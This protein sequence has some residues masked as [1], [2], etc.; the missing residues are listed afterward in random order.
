MNLIHYSDRRSMMNSIE[1]RMPF[2]DHRLVEF[3]A[4]IAASYKIHKGF[5]KYYA[6]LAFQ[7]LLPD[8]VIW[9]KDKNGWNTPEKIWLDGE[10]KY[11]AGDLIR[12]FDNEQYA[13]L[14][15]QKLIEK[16]TEHKVRVL[17]LITFH[18]IFGR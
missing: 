6:R 5:T 7:D 16:S 4:S 14:Y 1:S 9:R 15:L 8:E 10:L 13:P 17:N 11:W 12:Q 2:M 3:N 18:K